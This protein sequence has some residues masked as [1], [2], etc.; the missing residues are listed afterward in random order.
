MQPDII[1]ITSPPRSILEQNI[2]TLFLRHWVGWWGAM[3]N[4]YGYVS[5]QTK[6]RAQHIDGLFSFLSPIGMV[7]ILVHF[8]FA[9][10]LPPIGGSRAA[11][12]AHDGENIVIYRHCQ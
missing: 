1:T 9:S 11:A 3:D 8:S 2:L 6:T 10:P 12:S 7:A 5:Q 4:Q